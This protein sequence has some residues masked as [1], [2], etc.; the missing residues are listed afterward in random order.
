MPRIIIAG[1]GIAGLEALLALCAHLGTRAEIELLET[2]TALSQR[3]RAVAEPFGAV[4]APDTFTGRRG[5][6]A[7]G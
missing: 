4:P 7:F 5:V 3:Q 1:G 2:G 6:A